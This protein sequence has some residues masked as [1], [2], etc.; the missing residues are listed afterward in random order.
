[1]YFLG[2]ENGDKSP[3]KYDPASRSPTRGSGKKLQPVSTSWERTTINMW[4]AN[5][6]KTL[7]KL[8]PAVWRIAFHLS[9]VLMVNFFCASR[10]FLWLLRLREFITIIYLLSSATSKNN[11]C[12]VYH[13]RCETVRSTIF[14]FV[15]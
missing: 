10:I 15:T 4:L 8:R 13:S 1:M 2:E 5:C 14:H 11:V 7:K 12:K 3:T 6:L 9:W